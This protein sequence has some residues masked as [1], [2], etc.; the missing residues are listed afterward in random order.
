MGKIS[1]TKRI[2]FND[3]VKLARE[4]KEKGEIADFLVGK[5]LYGATEAYALA[6]AAIMRIH[7]DL[8]DMSKTDAE[9]LADRKKESEN[10]PKGYS[11][12]ED[13]VIEEE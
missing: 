12:G 7:T 6:R 9:I 2:A 8:P 5:Y 1:Q 4:G 3:A 10:L 13:G 11:Y